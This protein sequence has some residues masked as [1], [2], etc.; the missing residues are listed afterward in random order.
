MKN[1][2]YIVYHNLVNQAEEH[3]F[4]NNNVDSSL[5]FYNKAFDNYDYIFLRDLMNATQI[6]YF[7]NRPYK[8]YLY[9]AFEFGL[10]PW[11][12]KKIDLFSPIADSLLSSSEFQSVYESGRT[13]YLSKI[14]FDY[15][16]DIYVMKIQDQLNKRKDNYTDFKRE[17]LKTL[18]TRISDRGY[19][20]SKYLGVDCSTIFSEIGRPEDDYDSK[21]LEYSDILGYSS[22]DS[23]S[24]SSTIAMYL[25]IH[26]QCAFLEL[27]HWF[28][29]AV[30]E[31]EIHP[32]EVGLL[33]DNM[34]RNVND[35]N[36]YPCRYPNPY[37]GMFI[38]NNLFRHEKYQLTDE[39]INALRRKWFVCDIEVDRAKARYA[40]KFGFRVRYGFWNCM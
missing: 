33:Y 29:Q 36:K 14:D 39:K 28:Y 11:H 27:E 7:S 12:I 32:R 20:G 40:S 30:L 31:G 23:S 3:F 17:D 24:L 9:R 10:E 37:V 26:N 38:L 21:K 34:Y 5:H 15:L 19:P 1:T 18:K 16:L 4:L 8:K 22:P 25:L 6:A 35:P 2:T 13:V